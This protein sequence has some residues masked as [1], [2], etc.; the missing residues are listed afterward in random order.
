MSLLSYI[1]YDS[2]SYT[3]IYSQLYS[4]Q[5]I[6][7]ATQVT[8]VISTVLYLWTLSFPTLICYGIFVTNQS[9]INP[10]CCPNSFVQRSNGCRRAGEDDKVLTSLKQF[11]SSIVSILSFIPQLTT[12]I[13]RV[14][15]YMVPIRTEKN[16]SPD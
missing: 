10:D 8:G 9:V 6:R 1:V 3:Y 4:I 2:Y 5:Y 12:V 13:Y 14:Q 11:I 15:L 7:V 16:D